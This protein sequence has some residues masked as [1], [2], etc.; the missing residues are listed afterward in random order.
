[1]SYFRYFEVGS[2]DLYIKSG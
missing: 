1:M 2:K